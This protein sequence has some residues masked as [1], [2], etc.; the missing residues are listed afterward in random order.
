MNADNHGKAGSSRCSRS[1]PKAKDRRHRLG[2]VLLLGGDRVRRCCTARDHHAGDLRALPRS[3]PGSCGAASAQ[4]GRTVDVRHAIRA[5]RSSAAWHGRHRP[6]F[7]VVMLV[8]FGA[9]G[10]LGAAQI[11]QTPACCT[12]SRR[13]TRSIFSRA[14]G[15]AARFDG[16]SASGRGLGSDRRRRR[17]TRTWA[18]SAR[19]RSDRLVLRVFPALL[20][21]YFG[22]GALVPARSSAAAG[23]SSRWS[24]R[25]STLCA[26]VARVVR[27]RDRVPG[28]DLRRFFR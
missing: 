22:Q 24:A 6:V 1:L 14:T 15:R 9:I 28:A 23:R 2:F 21:A 3:R 17:S 10:A 19:V 5:V 4:C 12:R 25:A 13:G 16:P 11:A 7:G 26:G 20:C 8:W 27:H 18:T